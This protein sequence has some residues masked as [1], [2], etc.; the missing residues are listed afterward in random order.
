MPVL[1]VGDDRVDGTVERC[2]TTLMPAPLIAGDVIAGLLN[3]TKKYT[4]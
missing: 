3:Q 1:V 2:A 4:A